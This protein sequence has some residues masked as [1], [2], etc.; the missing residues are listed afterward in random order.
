MKFIIFPLMLLS[1]F[2]YSES[3]EVLISQAAYSEISQT[4]YVRV[5]ACARCKYDLYNFDQNLEVMTLG[6]PNIKSSIA[7]LLRDYRKATIFVIITNNDSNNLSKIYYRLR[8]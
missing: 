6:N 8:G 2:C 3:R 4:G 7:A 5:A 1:T